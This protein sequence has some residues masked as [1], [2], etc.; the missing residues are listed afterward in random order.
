M[1]PENEQECNCGTIG[2]TFAGHKQY[3]AGYY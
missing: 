1:K 2:G 3:T